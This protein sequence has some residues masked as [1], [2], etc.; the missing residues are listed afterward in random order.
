MIA[1]REA[2]LRRRDIDLMRF[3]DEQVGKGARNSLR[4]CF[5]DG[6]PERAWRKRHRIGAFPPDPP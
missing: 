6:S 5:A 3:S 1:Q 4:H 2:F